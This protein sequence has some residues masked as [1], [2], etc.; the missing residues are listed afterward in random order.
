MP[1]IQV[2]NSQTIYDIAL[3]HYGSIA[4]AV[5]VAQA[6]GMSVTDDAAGITLTLPELST[7]PH[8]NLIVKKLPGN[9]STKYPE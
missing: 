6:N 5:D 9:I 2:D 3:L 7:M 4:Y 8:E 1:T